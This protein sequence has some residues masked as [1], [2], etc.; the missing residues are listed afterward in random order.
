MKHLL[1]L[2]TFSLATLVANAQTARFEGEVSVGTLLAFDK[3]SV[4]PFSIQATGLYHLTPRFSI[5]A[6]TGVH[7]YE[8]P[9]IP[10]F[11]TARFLL[12]RPRKFTPYLTCDA[13]YAFAPSREANGGVYL[14]PGVGV[15]WTMKEHLKLFL[16]LG[17]EMQRLERL[18][19]HTG[20]NFQ[21]SYCE[22]LCHKGIAIKIGIAF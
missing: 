10:L 3:P 22:Q 15:R 5:G 6:G 9:L 8:T 4:T 18:K 12:T 1:I 17:Y 2:L 7:I 21:A 20:A 16:G 19:T 11:G 13:G 14:D